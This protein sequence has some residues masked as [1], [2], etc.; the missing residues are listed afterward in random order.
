[1]LDGRDIGT[2]VCPE[3]C[4]KLFV[5]AS[6]AERARR[7]H[8]ELTARGAASDL[9]EVRANLAARDD[10]DAGRDAAPLVPAADAVTLDTSELDAESAFARALAIVRARCG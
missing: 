7:R 3:A 10:R 5:T 8:L 4:A 1:V 9:D 2:V 6:L